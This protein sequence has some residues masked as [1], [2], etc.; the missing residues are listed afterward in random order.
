MD[1]KLT[2][3][4]ENTVIEKAKGYA[5]SNKI[6]LSRLIEGYLDSLTEKIDEESTPLVA[7][8]AGIISLNETDYKKDYADFL[9][10]KY[11]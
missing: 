7:S 10:E 9:S 1:S 8:L 3:K 6:S 5:K 4:L 2:L 11:K